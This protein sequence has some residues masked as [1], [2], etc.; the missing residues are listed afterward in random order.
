M[1]KLDIKPENIK[2]TLEALRKATVGLTAKQAL[3]LQVYMHAVVHRQD[4]TAVA[5]GLQAARFIDKEGFSLW[6]P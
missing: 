1:S 3:A 2:I 4:P 6:A 5:A